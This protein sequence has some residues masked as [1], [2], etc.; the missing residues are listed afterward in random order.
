[1]K[2]NGYKTINGKILI[3][4]GLH[5]GAGQ[6]A[7]QI[8]GVDNPM[9]RHPITE[10]PYIPG[11]SLK[12]KMRS[13][14]ELYMGKVVDNGEVH[15]YTNECKETRCPICL[16]FGSA[17]D[18][19]E[20]SKLGPGRLIVRDC[21]IDL[22]DKDNK[23]I[24]EESKGLP[25]SEEKTEIAINRITSKVDRGL[26]KT[27]RVPAGARFNLEL[28]IREFEGDDGGILNTVLK[29]LALLERDALGGSGSRG[30]GRIKFED[31]K[32]EAG[33]SIQLPEV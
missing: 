23:R 7:T 8:G 29:G 24:R 11:S 4:T 26:R 6:E 17:A 31:L 16:V 30:Y 20:G 25:F 2:L 27:E 5:I 1:M 10:M 32:D 15:K 22:D 21:R 28:T 9:I 33:N 14:L 13:L 3:L 12:G 19:K 18:Q